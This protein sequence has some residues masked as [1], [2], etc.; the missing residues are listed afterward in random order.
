MKRKQK[1]II[2]IAIIIAVVVSVMA[3]I[4]IQSKPKTTPF[5]DANSQSIQDTEPES[6][7]YKEYAALKGE[8]YDKA[9]LSGMIV[10]HSVAMTM[11]EQ[12]GASTKREEI[13]N[14][15]TEIND[16]QS[17]GMMEMIALQ[18]KFGFPITNG[19]DMSNMGNAG[20]SM[21][22]MMTMSEELQGLTGE[23]FDKKFLE[24]MVIHHKDAMDMSRSAQTN[25]RS[26]EVKDL[27]RSIISNQQQEI[28]QMKAWQ[29]EWGF[30]DQ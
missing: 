11:S 7:T 28:D 25:A 1:I 6:A 16:A 29:I 30:V 19:H 22:A 27:A 15:T 13:L 23:A 21:D 20:A 4:F 14:L 3:Y 8:S 10:H 9:F 12:A 5:S 24:S 18:T 2:S 17:K 26:Q